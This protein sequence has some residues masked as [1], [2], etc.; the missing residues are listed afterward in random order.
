MH[1]RS[2]H[3]YG[4]EARPIIPEYPKFKPLE[5]SDLDEVFVQL[6]A[7]P[8]TTCELSPVNLFS[9][10]DFDHP[11]V[12]L[13]NQNICFHLFPEDEADYFLEP[14]G[15][16]RVKETAEACLKHSSRISRVSEDFISRLPAE[17]FEVVPTRDQFDYFYGREELAELK[18]KKFDAKRN[19]IK[20]FQ[21]SFPH[22]AY[23]PL[24]PGHLAGALA[25]FDKWFASAS[26]PEF[27]HKAQKDALVL[28]FMNF[29][30]LRASG[31]AILI[32]KKIRGFIMGSRLDRKTAALH[33]SY[34][35]PELQGISQALLWEACNKT[36]N[37]YQLIDLEQDVGIPGLRKAKLSYHP[38]RLEKKFDL[39]IIQP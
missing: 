22:Y 37:C 5:L 38:L 7:I 26:L 13:I 4:Q 21:M 34:T 28:S 10:K 29:E 2:L 39:K 15:R 36:F 33:F 18:G 1:P 16:N 11:Q 35:D 8:R 6:D 30:K 3:L 32:D 31:G 12:S 24:E 19:H 9:W 25:L 17:K 23:V 27:E 14:L 20:K